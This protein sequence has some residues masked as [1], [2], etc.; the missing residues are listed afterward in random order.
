[1][2]T[3]DRQTF[4]ISAWVKRS[5][6]GTAR[7][8]IISANYGGAT[9]AFLFSSGDKLQLY[10]SDAAQYAETSGRFRDPSAWYHIAAVVATT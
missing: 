4:T 2:A 6:F 10:R 7:R 9:D 8:T 3:G 1:M 5:E